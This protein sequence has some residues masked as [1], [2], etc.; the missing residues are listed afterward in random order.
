GRPLLGAPVPAGLRDHAQKKSLRAA[1]QDRADVACA[2]AAWRAAQA[3]LNG[4]SLVFLDEIWATTNMARLRGRSPRG[5]RLVSAVPHGHWKT[6]TFLAAL[7]ADG[8][9]APLV[10]DG[11]INGPAFRAYVE[12]FLAPALR[13][14]D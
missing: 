3:G 10:L 11:A 13:P 8:L 14:G 4:A 2:R 1:E 7:R 9:V 12:Q 5:E 6:S